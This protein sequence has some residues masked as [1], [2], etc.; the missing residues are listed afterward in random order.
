MS[1]S[2][3][4]GKLLQDTLQA[5]LRA[6]RRGF[7]AG[8]AR[9]VVWDVTPQGTCVNGMSLDHFLAQAG[10]I[11]LGSGRLYRWEDTLVF[12]AHDPDGNRL[13]VVGD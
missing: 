2:P 9:P 5:N 3:S 6:L 12:D 13:R 11:L 7:P 8:S 1:A 4:R 10:A